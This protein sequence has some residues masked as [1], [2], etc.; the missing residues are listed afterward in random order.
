M[1][2]RPAP[3]PARQ[4]G[5]GSPAGG[6]VRLSG[7]MTAILLYAAAWAGLYFLVALLRFARLPAVLDRALRRDDPPGS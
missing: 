6:E 3:P 2:A 1:G 4:G 5:R 7:R